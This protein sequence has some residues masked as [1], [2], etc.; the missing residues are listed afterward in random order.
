MAGMD[1]DVAADSKAA[2]L[3]IE[4]KEEEKR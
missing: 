1:G 3:L 4:A 2:G